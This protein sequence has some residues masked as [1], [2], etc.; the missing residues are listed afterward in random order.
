MGLSGNAGKAIRDSKTKCLIS[1]RDAVGVGLLDISV[2]AHKLP[3]YL[4]TDQFVITIV[5]KLTTML[6]TGIYSQ[7]IAVFDGV[8]AM[9]KISRKSGQAQVQREIRGTAET[10]IIAKLEVC[11]NLLRFLPHME[12]N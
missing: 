6:D 11:V 3:P 12:Y 10:G 7:I 4:T 9:G 2:E 5:R 1:S 8:V